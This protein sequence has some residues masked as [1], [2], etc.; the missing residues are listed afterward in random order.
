MLLH[1]AQDENFDRARRGGSIPDENDSE[2]TNM[3]VTDPIDHSRVALYLARVPKPPDNYMFS[4]RQE[5]KQR[6]FFESFLS[7]SN[8]QRFYSELNLYRM[9]IITVRK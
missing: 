2:L 3:I 5:R 7:C 9:S 8:Q 4:Y 6:L 1:E